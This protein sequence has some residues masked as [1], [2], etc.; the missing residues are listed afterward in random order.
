VPER[1]LLWK[2]KSQCEPW[3]WEHIYL[4]G[5][6][7]WQSASASQVIDTPGELDPYMLFE[8]VLFEWPA[9]KSLSLPHMGA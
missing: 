8:T 5:K 7:G 9:E 2:L 6:I 3:V 4:P 1:Q